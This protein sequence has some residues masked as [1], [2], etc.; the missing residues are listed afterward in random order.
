MKLRAL[1]KPFGC[2]FMGLAIVMAAG[3]TGSQQQ[4]NPAQ[5]LSAI[6]AKYAGIGAKQPIFCTNCARLSAHIISLPGYG[7]PSCED[8]V[9]LLGI[10]A[11]LDPDYYIVN[12]GNLASN[13][14]TL[15]L[16]WYD[17]RGK[18]NATQTIPVPAIPAG[19]DTVVTVVN[20]GIVVLESEGVTLTL[21]YTDSAGTRHVVRKAKKCPDK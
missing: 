19:G 2:L 9:E 8:F 12:H 16:Q 6:R 14:G 17:L 3:S 18:G 5:D 1:I 20:T 7:C 10:V 13:P 4:K 21:D 15:T 11:W